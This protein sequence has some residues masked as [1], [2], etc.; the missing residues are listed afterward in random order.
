MAPKGERF[1]M[2]LDEELLER[3]D[4]WRAEQP[5]LP[6]RSESARRLI[7][8]G[9]S[10]R[11]GEFD[12]KSVSISDAERLIISLLCDLHK[13][14][15]VQGENDPD[16]IM[17]SILGGHFWAFKMQSHLFHSHVDSYSIVKEVIDTLDMWSFIESA[18]KKIG[19]AE[20]EQLE[21]ARLTKF[22]GYDGHTETDHMG[23]AHHLIHEMGRF[24]GFKKRA[25]DSHSPTVARY[26]RMY[27]V[28]EPLRP[29]LGLGRELSFSQLTQILGS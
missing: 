2:R 20:Q 6:S 23:V 9:L 12:S 24:S 3:V 7:D 13:A 8:Y 18:V 29:T 27:R 5:D 19:K 15:N 22:I 21:P 4:A 11:R 17:S 1:E 16:F 26:R 28:F 10:V 14:Q 25:L